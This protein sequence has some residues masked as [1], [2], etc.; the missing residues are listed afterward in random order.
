MENRVNRQ[1]INRASLGSGLSN[2]RHRITC[3][4]SARPVIP[5][6]AG[7]A[8]ASG[9]SFLVNKE[10]ICKSR[11]IRQRDNQWER[12]NVLN[13]KNFLNPLQP[14]PP[15][16]YKSI[17]LMVVKLISCEQYP[18]LLL[19]R[20]SRVKDDVTEQHMSQVSSHVK[21]CRSFLIRH[22]YFE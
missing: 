11:E 9:Q 1:R 7:P 15:C 10:P 6:A 2:V 4:T 8:P 16:I 14:G 5:A 21:K 19:W 18:W 20:Q 22:L 17:P 12:E 13:M 3:S